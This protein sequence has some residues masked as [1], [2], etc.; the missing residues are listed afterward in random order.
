MHVEYA[1]G[2]VHHCKVDPMVGKDANVV[3]IQPFMSAEMPPNLEVEESE[4]DNEIL[5]PEEARKYRAITA[6]L[7]YLAPDRVDIQF[8][9]KEAARGMSSPKSSDWPKLQRIGR[10]FLGRPRLVV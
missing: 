8:A 10:Y 2:T 9:V 6:R 1:D 3:L 7:N 5:G 4:C